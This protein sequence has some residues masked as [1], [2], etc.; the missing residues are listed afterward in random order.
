MTIQTK[1]THKT[2]IQ[3]TPLPTYL[4]VQKDTI[5]ATTLIPKGRIICTTDMTNLNYHEGC[6]MSPMGDVFLH[7]EQSNAEIVLNTDDPKEKYR[8]NIVASRDIEGGEEILITYPNTR[9]QNLS[10]NDLIAILRKKGESIPGTK[11]E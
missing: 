4:S 8:I 2:K 9:R 6:I 1:P 3:R 10:R 11:Y 7:S 5:F